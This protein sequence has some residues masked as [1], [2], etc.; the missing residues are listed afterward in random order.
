MSTRGRKPP[1]SEWLRS[2]YPDADWDSDEPDYPSIAWIAYAYQYGTEGD[3][4][5]ADLAV[6]YYT[7][8]VLDFSKGV[9]FV[10]FKGYRPLPGAK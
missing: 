6:E 4:Q 5:C 1:Y 2:E 3:K 8:P 7:K 9:K 10:Q